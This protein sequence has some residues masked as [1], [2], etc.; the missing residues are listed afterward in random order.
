MR[1]IPDS[2]VPSRGFRTYSTV[3]SPRETGKQKLRSM[4]TAQSY[5]FLLEDLLAHSATAWKV[6]RITPVNDTHPD[7]NIGGHTYTHTVRIAYKN[8]VHPKGTWEIIYGI[9]DTKCV[10]LWMD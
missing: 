10:H 9:T 6:T 1:Q 3:S 4:L 7:K 5:E 8:A 2:S